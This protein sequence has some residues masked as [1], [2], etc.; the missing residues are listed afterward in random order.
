MTYKIVVG[1][2]AA[3]SAPTIYQG[4]HS[5]L[6]LV[7][8]KP[9]RGKSTSLQNLPPEHTHLINV[10]GKELPFPGGTKYIVGQNM[11]ITS[12]APTIREKMKSAALDPMLH[13]LVVDDL[14][15]VMATE[16]MDKVMVK[17]Y[18]KFSVMARNIWDLLIQANQLRGGL[19]VFFLTHEE[20]TTTERKMKT[21]GKLLDEKISPEGLSTIVLWGE[22][23]IQEQ[24]SQRFFFSTQTDG[25]TN[26]KAPVGMF[27]PEI[28]NDLLLVSQR[29]DEYYQGVPMEKSKVL[30]K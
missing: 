30:S 12:S 9:G 15:Y 23:E 8:S 20:E 4:Q 13:Y 24:H 28:P 16:F 18:D 21:L 27:P 29:I 1:A 7:I 10:M 22:V 14:H 26:A 17:G 19:K 3:V 11:T 6:V 25:H 2:T 5:I